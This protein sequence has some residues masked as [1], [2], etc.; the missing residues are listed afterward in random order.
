M[1]VEA[2]ANQAKGKHIE[3]LFGKD[4]AASVMAKPEGD[5]PAKD[6]VI[7]SKGMEGFY[8]KMLVDK[9]NALGKKYGAKVEQNVPLSDRK[10]E[11]KPNGNWQVTDAAGN[12]SVSKSLPQ[13]AGTAHVLP[14]TPELRKAVLEQGFPLYSAAGAGAALGASMAAS[15]QQA[16]PGVED[17][18]ARLMR[19][20]QGGAPISQTQ[21][22]L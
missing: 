10:I 8:D 1:I 22:G 7:G 15:E 17:E 18:N 4:M 11:Q 12:V 14:I 2:S 19:A 3:E 6:F 21:G 13:D 20:L 5:I 16:A 9:A